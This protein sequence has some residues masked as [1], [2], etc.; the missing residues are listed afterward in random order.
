MFCQSEASLILFMGPE[1]SCCTERRSS[2]FDYFTI[3]LN[4]GGQTK[5][6]QLFT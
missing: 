3:L 5:K 6:T 4:L 1:N 2:S